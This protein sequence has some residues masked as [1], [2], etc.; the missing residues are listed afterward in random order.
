MRYL[1]GMRPIAVVRVVALL[2]IVLAVAACSRRLPAEPAAEAPVPS[3]L[4]VPLDVRQFEVVTADGY[5]G[6][7]LKLSR[8]PDSIDYY[9]ESN[10]NRIVVDVKGPTGAEMPEESYPGQDTLVSQFRILRQF[11]TL[12]IALELQG[13]ELPAYSVHLM[14]DWIMIRIAPTKVAAGST[15][16]PASIGE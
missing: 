14:A 5:R 1:P 16:V 15:A 13:D 9:S 6:V 11:G 12:R 8:L 3:G 10:P 7:F 2:S 4:S